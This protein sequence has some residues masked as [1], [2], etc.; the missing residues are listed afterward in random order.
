MMSPYLRDHLLRKLAL[1]A[2]ELI[3]ISFLFLLALYIHNS[4][5]KLALLTQF[6]PF[7]YYLYLRLSR[8]QI[9]NIRA[10]QEYRPTE[11]FLLPIS[12]N[13]VLVFEFFN[14][15]IALYTIFV[16]FG[17]L[18]FIESLF[19]IKS[20]RIF[21]V[22]VVMF[23]AFIFLEMIYDVH[24]GVR[25]K[26]TKLTHYIVRIARG[27]SKFFLIILILGM[28]SS[29]DQKFKTNYFFPLACFILILSS[30]F[31][32]FHNSEKVYFNEHKIFN[33]KNFKWFDLIGLLPL[34]LF[35]VAFVHLLNT[36]EHKRKPSS[37]KAPDHQQSNN[38]NKQ[39][40]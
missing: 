3:I 35:I 6:L 36:D 23:C 2:N 26:K 12:K 24:L 7:V 28:G 13:E 27:F 15:I 10:Q 39:L 5:S 40:E 34:F 31:F 11:T 16:G 22:S 25:F 14:I 29:F 19:E 17:S 20:I 38:A 4:N 33:N 9:I 30:I 8:S 37:L 1:H 18:L 32:L 21:Q